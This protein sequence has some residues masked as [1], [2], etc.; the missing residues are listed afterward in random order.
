MGYNVL[1]VPGKFVGDLP[2]LVGAVVLDD[3]QLYVYIAECILPG[4]SL[5]W[6]SSASRLLLAGSTLRCRLGAELS[7]GLYLSRCPSLN[8]IIIVI[9]VIVGSCSKL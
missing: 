1:V 4:T 8:I 2:S 6:F 9:V 5:G 7:T 3:N